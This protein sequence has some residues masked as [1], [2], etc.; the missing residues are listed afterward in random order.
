MDSGQVTRPELL[1]CAQEGENVGRATQTSS[2]G[3]ETLCEES[4][5]VLSLVIAAPSMVVVIFFQHSGLSRL[6]AKVT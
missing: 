6:G 4:T 3:C 2:G 1:L 5:F